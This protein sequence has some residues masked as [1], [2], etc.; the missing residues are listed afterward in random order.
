VTYELT[1]KPWDLDIGGAGSGIW[2]TTDG[3][4][5]W[6]RLR[7]RPAVGRIGR[8]GID[9]YQANPDILYAIVENANVREPTEAEAKRDA[10]RPKPSEFVVGKRGVPHRRRRADVEEDAPRQHQHREQGG[11]FVQHPAA[12]TR[13]IRP[14][15]GHLRRDANSSDG[16]KTWQGTSWPPQACS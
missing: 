15:G 6:T 7:R 12:S 3:G 11:V 9:L 2:K 5:K 16:G 1:R 10:A 8:I 13:A 14:R 4:R